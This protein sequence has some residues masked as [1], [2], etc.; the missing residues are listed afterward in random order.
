MPTTNNKTNPNTLPKHH[1]IRTTFAA[2]FGFFALSLIIVAILVVWLNV[3][4]SST[5]QYTKTVAPLV[6]NPDV[7]VFV[8]DK[9]STAVLENEGAPIR[10]IATQLLGESQVTGTTDEQLRAAVTPIVKD[11]L[12]SVIA[13]PAFAALWKTSNSAIHAQLISQLKSDSPTI[14]LNFHPLVADVINELGTTKLGFVKDKLEIKDDAGK[15]TIKEKQLDNVRNVYDYF[16]K[17]MLAIIALAILSL[18]LCVIIS[19]HH[20]KTARRIALL[21]GIFA[22]VLAVLL[23]ATSLI[24]IGGDDVVQQKFAVAL[25]N[26]VTHDLRLALIIVAV[27]GIGGAVASKIYDTIKAKK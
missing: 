2:L 3:T 16:Q 17:A 5:D 7:Q 22:A 9:A 1:Y 6:T 23:S 14:E 11:S 26:G 10:D 18:V 19:V 13:S 25:I 4:I 20:V 24:K 27:L 12:R 21:T 15:V 8:V